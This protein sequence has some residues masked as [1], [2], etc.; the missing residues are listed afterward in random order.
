MLS[1]LSGDPH[2][3]TFDQARYDF[4]APG[5]F[6][7]VRSDT[8]QVQVLNV[9]CGRAAST[10]VPVGC[11]RAVAARVKGS[12]GDWVEKNTAVDGSFEIVEGNNHLRIKVEHDSR[13]DSATIKLPGSFYSSILQPSLCGNFDLNALNDVEA[14]VN[15]AYRNAPGPPPPVRPGVAPTPWRTRGACI[16]AP[17]HCIDEDVRW[18][19][20]EA[21]NIF[22]PATTQEFP[23]TFGLPGDTSAYNPPSTPR[24][25]FCNDWDESRPTALQCQAHAQT[26]EAGTNYPDA[27]TAAECEAASVQAI[28][29]CA[30]AGVAM[31][32]CIVDVC[33]TGVR[34]FANGNIIAGHNLAVELGV[35]EPG[36]VQ[37]NTR[38]TVDACPGGV[39]SD[40][41]LCSSHGQCIPH[42]PRA[43][44]F[45]CA[46]DIGWKGLTCTTPGL[47]EQTGAALHDWACDCPPGTGGAY[48]EQLVSDPCTTSA[49]QDV[50]AEFDTEGITGIIVWTRRAAGLLDMKVQLRY[51]DNTAAPTDGHNWHVHTNGLAESANCAAAGGHYDPRGLEVGDYSCDSSDQTS[52]A[53]GD[54]S[55]KFGLLSIDGELRTGVDSVLTL[56]ELLGKSVVIHAA[57]AG[58]DRIA[59]AEIVAGRPNTCSPTGTRQCVVTAVDEFG[60]ECLAGWG[61][62]DCSEDIDECCSSPCRAN[63]ICIDQIDGYECQTPASFSAGM[64]AVAVFVEDVACDKSVR[65]ISWLFV[66]IVLVCLL[67]CC[68]SMFC[69]VVKHVAVD[70]SAILPTGNGANENTLWILFVVAGEQRHALE[71]MSN[72]FTIDVVQSKVETATGV[73]VDEQQLE[74]GGRQLRSGRKLTSYGVQHGSELVLKRRDGGQVVTRQGEQISRRR[75]VKVVKGRQMI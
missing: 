47:P 17:Y 15:A 12:S 9:P 13:A 43:N 53:S 14:A 72:E 37:V 66:V 19:V 41:N 25:I 3:S 42:P 33:S 57:G 26:A 55:G 60:C 1:L 58:T 51:K 40:M 2:Y 21:D 56:A 39:C 35:A 65:G 63:Q 10:E 4:M 46:C 48:C 49:T 44:E 11:T 30:H 59:C 16:S 62:A 68:R 24:D 27:T 67:A 45:V 18:R 52:C 5:Y 74:Y 8:V 36:I 73:P 6:W 38:C 75:G 70:D 64:E 23:K 71:V 31:D 69:G 34:E 32:A 22:G 20:L 29:N 61:G 7:A 50:H 54:L 28:E